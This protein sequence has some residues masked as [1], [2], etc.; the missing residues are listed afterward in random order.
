VKLA[1]ILHLLEVN[2]ELKR[3]LKEAVVGNFNVLS[4]RSS[5]GT[6]KNHTTMGIR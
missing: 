4:Q 3:I 6:E 1:V 5:G 2:D